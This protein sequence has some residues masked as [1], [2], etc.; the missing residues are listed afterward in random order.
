M[1]R[2]VG[3]TRYVAYCHCCTWCLVMQAS[4]VRLTYVVRNPLT[5][6]LRGWSLW[7]QRGGKDEDSHSTMFALIYCLYGQ[8][9]IVVVQQENYWSL[10][11]RLGMC[12]GVICISY[13]MI[14]HHLP[15]WMD[16]VLNVLNVPCVQWQC[17]W[18]AFYISLSCPVAVYCQ[19]KEMN[20]KILRPLP[21]YVP[22]FRNALTSRSSASSRVLLLSDLFL[23]VRII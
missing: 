2:C 11:R 16:C 7:L 23:Q 10:F 18:G 12:S 4:H 5:D 8:M 22:R 3:G 19:N 6:L 21:V 13:K 20:L 14:L 1:Q 15:R 9:Q 17:W